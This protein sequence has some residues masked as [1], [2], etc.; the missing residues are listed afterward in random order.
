[1]DEG[2]R[3]GI[4]RLALGEGLCWSGVLR[5]L[6]DCYFVLLCVSLNYWICCSLL[7]YSFREL[8]TYSL[9]SLRSLSAVRLLP[10]SCPSD[11]VNI[12]NHA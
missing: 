4:G 1:M 2:L 8:L 12:Q 10:F 5:L 3:D 9:I 11:P 7:W 6:L